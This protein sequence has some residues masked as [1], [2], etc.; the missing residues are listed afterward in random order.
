MPEWFDKTSWRII[1]LHSKYLL[2]RWC[3][4]LDY[5]SFIRNQALFWLDVFAEKNIFAYDLNQNHQTQILFCLMRFMI[6]GFN[7][8]KKKMSWYSRARLTIKYS[9]LFFYPTTNYFL[10]PIKGLLN[11]GNIT[12]DVVQKVVIARDRSSLHF[13][14]MSNYLYGPLST[15]KRH[16]LDLFAIKTVTFRKNT[17]KGWSAKSLLPLSQFGAVNFYVKSLL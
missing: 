13:N 16:I 8:L 6:C 17:Y 3:I 15:T 14:F 2:K 1:R 10:F 11:I 5:V 12:W 4:Q 9:T 7:F